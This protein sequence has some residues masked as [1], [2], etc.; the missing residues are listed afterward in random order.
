MGVCERKVWRYLHSVALVAAHAK[1][2]VV[3][4]HAFGQRQ[5]LVGAHHGHVKAAAL[6]L[7]QLIYQHVTGCANLALEFASSAQ[8]KSLAVGAAVGE[9]GEMQ[10]NAFNPS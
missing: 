8:Q 10:I 4:Q 7:S 9:L 5:R 6:H 3:G 2:G 1:S